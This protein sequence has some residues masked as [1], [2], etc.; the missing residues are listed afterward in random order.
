MGLLSAAAA[1]T[2]LA[3]QSDVSVVVNVGD[4]RAVSKS[5]YASANFDWHENKEET[6]AWINMSAQLIDLNNPLL[7]QAARALAPAHLR[8]GGSEGDVVVYDVPEYN[9]TCSSMNMTD[10]MFCL[11][12]SRWEELVA[13]CQ[14]TGLRMVFGLDAMAGRDGNTGQLPLTNIEAFLRYTAQKRL[15][16]FGWELGNEKPDV[17]AAVMAKDYH[18][19]KAIIEKHWPDSADRPKLIGCDQNVNVKYIDEWLPL[20][21][22]VLDVLTYHHYDGYGLDKNLVNELMTPKFLNGTRQAGV[23]A[24][25]KKH[26]PD[27]DLWV[28]EA[29]A[30][31]HSGRDGVT[32]AF[33]SNFWYADALAGDAADGHTAYQRQ[34]LL[35]GYYGLLNRTTYEPNPD[36]Y[37]AK[38]HNTLMGN[39][40]L[41]TDLSAG[42]GWVRGYAQCTPE[43][44]KVT[45]LL[46]NVDSKRTFVLSGGSGVV[47]SSRDEYVLTADS[48]ASRSVNLNG[49][50]LAVAGGKLPDLHPTHAESDTITLPP[51]TVAYY[52]LSGH[53]SC[54]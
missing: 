54:K 39:R 11:K 41:Q 50:P 29:A 15:P 26:A 23:V 43:G 17:P 47:L 28:G 7:L 34:T 35:G 16:V 53:S 52:V 30:A 4:V 45:L 6:P 44:G 36:F 38:L 33:A 9:S 14:K 20:V 2:A 19:V 10:P 32:N 31:W 46:I 48:L 3:S 8:I 27:A 18:G 24:A 13:F 12:M 5:G 51:H 40:V 37:I 42:D 21:A 22:D 49:K 1:L 25:W